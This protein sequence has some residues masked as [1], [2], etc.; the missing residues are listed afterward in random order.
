MRH[1][2]RLRLVWAG[3]TVTAVF[4]ASPWVSFVT[5][6]PNGKHAKEGARG[7]KICMTEEC[8]A[9]M[10]HAGHK[11]SL[12]GRTADMLIASW[13]KAVQTTCTITAV[14]ALSRV[15]APSPPVVLRPRGSPL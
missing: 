15:A 11:S 10:L 8:H 6:A 2:R 1:R 4:V 5:G 12:N 3:C 13:P 14:C 9:L 7:A